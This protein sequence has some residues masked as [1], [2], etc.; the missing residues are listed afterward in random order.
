MNSKAHF[1]PKSMKWLISLAVMIVLSAG[2]IF[3][4][5]AIDELANKKY[6]EHHEPGF[7]IVST[8]A[9]DIAGYDTAS[10]NVSAVEKALD[11]SGN[12]V[13]YIV[14]GETVGYNQE[15]PIE[16][17]TT[18]SADGTLVCGVEIIHQ[19]ETEYLG[20]QIQGENFK[21]QFKGRLLPVVSS[22]DTAKGSTIDVIARSTI[23][24][25][26]VIDGVNNAV[27]FLGGANL[28]EAAE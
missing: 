8:E 24:S 6:N 18:V 4:S 3:G 1:N 13:A 16:M 5:K 25:E 23:S 20:V 17:A 11:A 19:N 2:V 15:E 27:D 22:A 14:T 10:F 26:A 7:T 12:V 21:N 9:I 28:I